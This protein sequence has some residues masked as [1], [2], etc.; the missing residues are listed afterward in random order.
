MDGNDEAMGGVTAIEMS[1]RNFLGGYVDG[2]GDDGVIA[3]AMAKTQERDGDSNG[4]V[5]QCRWRRLRR[6]RE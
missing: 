2:N 5:S 4:N 1:I 6:R 3:E